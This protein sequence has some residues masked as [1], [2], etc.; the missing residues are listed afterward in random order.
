MGV[1][2][3]TQ[4]LRQSRILRRLHDRAQIA[5]GLQV[6]ATAQLLPFDAWLEMQWREAAAARPELPRLLAPAAVEWLWRQR[7]ARD[8]PGLIDPAELG[9]KAR[10]SW[11]R[12]RAHGGDVAGLERWPLTRDQQAFLSWA[13]SVETELAERHVRD[14]ADLTRQF[15]VMQAAPAAGP[16]L[17]LSGFRRL[18]PAQ[19]A[20]VAALRARGWSVHIDSPATPSAGRWR[21][22]AASPEAEQGAA[23]A[24]IHA[25]LERRPEGI[26]GLILPDLATRRGAVERALAAALQPELE[27]PGAAAGDRVFDLAGGHPLIAQPLVETAIALLECVREPIRWATVSRLLRSPHIDGAASER[28]ARTK[29]DLELRTIEPSLQWTSA[30]LRARAERSGAKEFAAKLVAAAGAMRGA[31]RRRMGAWAEVFGACLTAWGWPGPSPL[32]SNEFQAAQAFSER[33][34]ELSRLDAV[35]AELTAA[36]ALRELRRSAAAPF[37]PER[38]EPAVFVLDT[39]DD[40]GIRFDSLWVAGLNAAAWPSPV[41]VDPLLPIEIQ[42]KLGMP[43]VTAEGCVAE[44]RAVIERWRSASAELVLSWPSREND[45]DVDGSLLIP[46]TVPELP[47]Q[48][49]L[50]SRDQLA[51]AAGI[52]EPMP[53]DPAPARLPG[54]VRGGARVLELQSQ[55][56]F[57]AFAELRL[58]ARPL[59]EPQAGIDR[60]KRGTIL[61]RALQGFWSETRSLAGLLELD[62]QTRRNRVAAQVDAALARELPAGTGKRQRQLERDWQCLAIQN[63]LAIEQERP[64]FAVAESERSMDCD[65]GGLVLKLQVDRVDRIGDGLLVIDYKTG[66]ASPTQWR[67]ARMDAPQLPLYA[68]LHPGKPGGLAVATIAATG[69]RFRG[70][71]SEAGVIDNLLPAGK[72]EL[73]EDCQK[74]FNWRQIT[75]HWYA[76]LEQLARD[77]A[78]GRADV[79]PKLAAT[80]CRN[81][82]LGALCRVA[83]VAPDEVDAEGANDND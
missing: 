43:G 30:G 3:L 45:T 53:A 47:L 59:E 48:P 79:D 60:R 82:H 25:Q 37:Q 51:H 58:G 40:P 7:A 1:M 20:L 46:A 42:R 13:R 66:K 27:L 34:R 32:D 16:P 83:T 68:V 5:A 29:F 62:Q 18:T 38:G 33:L 73:T 69:A 35:M 56:P 70:I 81:C 12:L 52:L 9:A 17:R 6:W 75:E 31:A 64:D 49:L 78:A 28:N 77:H 71:A 24:W 11:I 19:D 67:G 76:W 55:C 74:G 61:H 57:R 15:V 14:P 8:A 36:E 39:L 4:N 80:T 23:L 22:E 21:H 41:A 65:L 44:A 10:A 50:R 2:L 54:T 63:L 72:F 26:H